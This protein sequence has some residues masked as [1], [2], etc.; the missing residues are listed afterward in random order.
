MCRG[1][2]EGHLRENETAAMDKF[3]IFLLMLPA[4]LVPSISLSKPSKVAFTA[5][6]NR[7]QLA[8]IGQVTDGAGYSPVTRMSTGAAVTIP[9]RRQFALQFGST[10]SQ[11]GSLIRYTEGFLEGPLI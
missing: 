11:K 5:G 4:F 10:Y 9:V 8:Y 6:V 3:P 2:Y 1:G 7:S